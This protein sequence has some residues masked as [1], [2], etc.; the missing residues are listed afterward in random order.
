MH[1]A[2]VIPTTPP[3]HF[4]P[5]RVLLTMEVRVVR[6]A[7]RCA[8]MEDGKS[9]MGWRKG[10]GRRGGGQRRGGWGRKD[11]DDGR[12]RSFLKD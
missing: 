8:R 10:R 2:P 7:G 11:V 5:A 4:D 3:C 12:G 6:K 9:R 1:S